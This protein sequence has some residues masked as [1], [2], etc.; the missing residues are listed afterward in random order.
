MEYI[1]GWEKLNMA[2]ASLVGAGSQRERLIEA[3]S[4][5]L[6]HIKPE[7]DLPLEMRAEFTQ[8]M[9]EMTGREESKPG[10]GRLEATV[11]ALGALEVHAAAEE[12][13]SFYDKICRYMPRR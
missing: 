10:Q 8:F 3:I 1:Y 4:F 6:S 7:N 9:D 13:L 2:V 5:S 12:V 11:Q